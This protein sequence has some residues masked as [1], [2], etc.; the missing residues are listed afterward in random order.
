MQ[1][2]YTAM[3]EITFPPLP[4]YPEYL[5]G[6]GGHHSGDGDGQEGSPSGDVTLWKRT[7]TT[8]R[9]RGTKN[10]STTCLMPCTKSEADPAWTMTIPILTSV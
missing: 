2:V 6:G 9:I 10:L 3:A 7:T 8:T 5:K 1:Q 4:I